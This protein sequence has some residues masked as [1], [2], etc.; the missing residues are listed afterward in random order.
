MPRSPNAA[1]CARRCPSHTA[2]GPPS[3][4]GDINGITSVSRVCS[5][6]AEFMARMSCLPLRVSAAFVPRAHIEFNEFCNSSTQGHSTRQSVQAN[7]QRH[8][9]GA[10][11][12]AWQYLLHAML[13]EPTPP[14]IA[15]QARN[16]RNT[17]QLTEQHQCNS[18]ATCTEG[19]GYNPVKVYLLTISTALVAAPLPRNVGLA[20]LAFCPDNQLES[21]KHA[22]SSKLQ[23]EH[24][25]VLK[26]V[27]GTCLNPR[28][29]SKP[30]MHQQPPS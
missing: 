13:R 25:G 19:I 26:P 24:M 12:H 18:A 9:C 4:H 27:D 5:G 17:M 11:W 8:S 6:E 16:H 15:Q 22:C 14:S 10:A 1:A 30:T 7:Q 20:L 23:P 28:T 21:H 2:L 29:H 3:P